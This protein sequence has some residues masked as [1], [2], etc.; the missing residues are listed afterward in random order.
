LFTDDQR[1]T[2]I[3]IKLLSNYAEVNL[4]QYW[5]V[6]AAASV[7]VGTVRIYV[8]EWVCLK[9][10]AGSWPT[11]GRH[12]ASSLSGCVKRNEWSDDLYL[13]EK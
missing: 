7:L 5:A 12:R 13:P 2:I 4:V 9:K 11:W 8:G 6:A 3:K 10:F 1:F